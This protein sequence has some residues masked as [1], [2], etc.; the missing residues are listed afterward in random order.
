MIATAVLVPLVAALVVLVNV[1]GG[2]G[3]DDVAQVEGAPT[4]QREDLPP[5]P[6]EAPPAAP[7]AEAPCTTLLGAMPLE[8]AGEL[9]RPVQSD[10][11]FVYAWG[12]P[13]VVLRCGVD[14]P[15]GFDVTASLIQINAVQWFVDDSDPDVVVWT[16]VDRPV[17]V[18][19]R[20]PSSI[21][22]GPAT[23]LSTI[24]ATTLPFQE[25]QPAQ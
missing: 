15:A 5:L 25:P 4:L 6:V 13:P 16:A 3:S 8:L 7:G 18:E 14:R 20:I 2:G 24:I 23:A 12:D 19:V 21:D 22:S 10:S 1:L 17:H 9:S 11:P